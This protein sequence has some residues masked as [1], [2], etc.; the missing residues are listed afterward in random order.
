MRLRVATVEDAPAMCDIYRPSV[1]DSAVSFEESP[2]DADEM[3]RRVR[4]TT[5]RYPWLVAERE[6]DVAGYA[7]AGQFHPREAYRWSVTVSVYV[8]AS[9]RRAGVGRTLYGALFE[10]LRHQRFV[11]AYALVTLP[12]RPSVGLHESLGFERVGRLDSVGHKRGT[13]RDVGYW[14]RRLREPPEDPETPTSFPDLS[15]ETLTRVLG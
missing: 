5:A 15:A 8:D 6:D 2:P 9:H 7:Y 14:H 1:T 12:N 3:A 13:W 11:N 4:E 10:L